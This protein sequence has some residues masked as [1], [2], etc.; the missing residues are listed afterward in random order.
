MSRCALFE[1]WPDK[2]RKLLEINLE[3]LE[4]DYGATIVKQ[5]EAMKGL[6]FIIKYVSLIS[7]QLRFNTSVLVGRCWKYMTHFRG[8]AKIVVDSSTHE[9]QF[10][11]LFDPNNSVLARELG[12]YVYHSLSHIPL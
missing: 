12:K 9:T 4:F 1:Q 6:F 11:K 8:E 7:R 2:M 5:G 3:K 10:P